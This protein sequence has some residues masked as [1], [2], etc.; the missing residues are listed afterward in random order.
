MLEG[1]DPRHSLHVDGN[2]HAVSCRRRSPR[3]GRQSA[4]ILGTVGR[5]H[6]TLPQKGSKFVYGPGWGQT[7][8]NPGTSGRWRGEVG[9]WFRGAWNKNPTGK[10]RRPPPRFAS[11]FLTEF[12]SWSGFSSGRRG[13]TRPPPC[14]D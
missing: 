5:T 12:S 4:P 3:A 1:N 7:F 13:A 14:P 8:A 9:S 6:P 11:V 10:Y 2:E